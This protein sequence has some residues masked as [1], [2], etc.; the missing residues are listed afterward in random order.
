ME[1][2]AGLLQAGVDLLHGGPLCTTVAPGPV[3]APAPVAAQARNPPFGGCGGGRG[4]GLC[5]LSAAA[6]TPSLPPR[7]A[8]LGSG[9]FHCPAHPPGRWVGQTAR[10][11]PTTPP[12]ANARLLS[13]LGLSFNQ[14][15]YLL[16]SVWML[17]PP[18]SCS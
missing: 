4:D 10:A 6:T 2:D 18:R 8:H 17:R 12:P 3:P 5:V 11:F 1:R 16:V 13:L 9:D 7:A 15:P 14:P